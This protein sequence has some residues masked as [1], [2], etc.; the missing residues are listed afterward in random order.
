MSPE[1]SLRA[2]IG[3][4]IRAERERQGLSQRD[5]AAAAGTTQR[6]FS[7]IENGAINLTANTI[8]D[9][10]HALGIPR[11]ARLGIPGPR[12]IPVGFARPAWPD[13]AP[14]RPLPRQTPAH[15]PTATPPPARHQAPP[16][17]SRDHNRVRTH[18]ALD[19]D[20][21]LGRS[22]Q[23]IGRITSGTWLG[24]LSWRGLCD[25]STGSPL[26]RAQVRRRHASPTDRRS[27]AASNCRSA[28][29]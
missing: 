7:E 8:E 15:R 2:R 28:R 22:V 27:R 10:A 14:S 4:R 26:H 17:Q 11:P 24:G 13:A 6:R 3:R 16:R 19:K 23:A 9:F 25:D 29:P 1:E 20:A 5:L 12:R 21:P 18:F